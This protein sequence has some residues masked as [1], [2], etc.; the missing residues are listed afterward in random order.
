MTATIPMVH[1]LDVL[2]FGL[3][4]EAVAQQCET[5]PGKE[6]ATALR[7]AFSPE[8]VPELIAETA[9]A[10]ELIAGSD[11]S[12]R[13]VHDVAATVARAAKG[14]VCD[15]E[16]LW[17]VGSLLLVA[18]QARKKSQGHL[19][20][21]AQQIA[22]LADLGQK[23]DRTLES[24]GQVKD[25][26]DAKL[27][28][29]RAEI[30]R[31]SDRVQGRLQAHLKPPRRDLL[32]DPIITTRSGRSVLPLKA[33]N[34]GKIKGIIHDASASGQTIFVEPEDVVEAGNSLRQAEAKAKAEELRILRSLSE[35]IGQNAEQ[36]MQ[37]AAAL[38]ELDLILGR[39]RLP[40]VLAKIEGE[41]RLLIEEGTHPAL[42]PEEAVPLSL[43]LG[44]EHEA[45]LITGPNTGGKTVALKTVGL[46]AA[47]I[48]AGC[49]VP[50]KT[51]TLGPFSQLW[52]DIGDEQSMQQS[53]STFSSHIKNIAEAL[54][55]LKPGALVVMDEIGAGTDPREGAALGRAL[56][57][58]F[59]RG[60]ARLMASTHYGELKAFADSADGFVNASM[61]FDRKSLRPTYELRVG[62]PGGS[63]ALAIAARY[64]IQQEIVDEAEAG[65]TQQEQDLGEMI[66]RL[67]Q[68]E[69]LARSAQGRADRTAEKLKHAQA[70]AEE[71]ERDARQAKQSAREEARKEFQ[72]ELAALKKELH[73]SLTEMESD[74]SQ[75]TV[76]ETKKQT[77]AAIEEVQKETAPAPPKPVAAI[78]KGMSVRVTHLNKL[79]QVMEEPAKGKALVQVGPMR[80]QLDLHQLEPFQ[81][82]SV[83]RQASTTAKGGA[84]KELQLRRMRAEEAIE[85]LDEFLDSAVLAGHGQVR[86]VHGKGG[87]VLRQITQDTLRA[88]PQV[89]SFR[90]GGPGEG[91]DGATVAVMK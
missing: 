19:P 28:D 8:R 32:S 89:D 73:E 30:K 62:V 77:V 10:R 68:A 22:D 40:G 76:Q 75:A 78:T 15:G 25:E 64:G 14:G 17:R 35:A 65:F 88:H 41:A 47:M 54:D 58:A 51:A 71:K 50:A 37:T 63:H 49:P 74:L 83:K 70:E 42:D 21:L 5:V 3:V 72:E 46:F 55:R 57:L 87:G 59:Q 69:K 52:A 79:G 2:E 86:I 7:P 48:Q 1:A 26:A 20:S 85:A 12:L 91:G 43:A 23:L 80:M 67:E 56:L 18:E 66:T 31:S 60:G 29:A 34:R 53:L 38:A 82:K 39:A 61:S 24:D 81:Q 9:A 11:I 27:A 36:I 33:E 84:P 90:L 13:G 44:D 4:R 16:D 45:I 6:R